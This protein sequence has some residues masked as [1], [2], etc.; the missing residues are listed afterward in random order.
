VQTGQS[1]LRESD[2]N[3]RDLKGAALH[4]RVKRR[5]N[6]LVGEIARHPEEY[7]R[8]RTGSFHQS[9][10]S[11]G[12]RLL[13]IAT[14]RLGLLLPEARSAH[15][16]VPVVAHAGVRRQILDASGISSA[17]HYVFGLQCLLEPFH[18]IGHVA[19]PVLLP[20]S[21]QTANTNVVLKCSPVLVRKMS[22]FHRL[23][24]PVNDHGRPESGAEAQKQHPASLVASESLHSGVIDNLDGT[25]E[26]LAE[27]E[28]DP[29]AAKIVG[30]V[31]GV[32]VNDGTRIADRHAVILPA[33]GEALDIPYHFGGGHLGTGWNPAFLALPGCHNLDMGSSDIDHQDP[34]DL[35]GGIAHCFFSM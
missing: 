11:L 29:A 33:L 19:A 18:H 25:V 35:L 28:S 24:Y 22:Q 21:L 30:L 5:K 6:H 26:R 3:Y 31:H 17:Q 10:P 13:L 12:G 4:H 14:E 23:E 32:S 8:V 34:T 16:R 9:S 20:K 15:K 27:I 7:Q 2:A 1:P